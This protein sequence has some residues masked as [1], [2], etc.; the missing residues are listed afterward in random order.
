[1]LGK[2]AAAGLPGYFLNLTSLHFKGCIG[3]EKCSK[4][5]LCTGREDDMTPLYNE[6]IQS[7]GLV[8]TCPAR[9]YNVT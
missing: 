4:D 1:M 7:Q 2:H 9:N 8:V 3:C 6:I 5:K